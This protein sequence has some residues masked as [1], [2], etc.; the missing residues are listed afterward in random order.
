MGLHVSDL[1]RTDT[2]IPEGLA[3]ESFLTVAVGHR[4]P[5][6]TSV[7]IDGRPTD[8]GEDPQAVPNRVV[9]SA[10]HHRGDPFAA[11]VAGRRCVERAATAVGGQG[12]DL[13]EVDG[14]LGR[15]H[16]VDRCGDGGVAVP[17]PQPLA[18]LVNRHKR[19]GTGGVDR[20]VRSL[21]AE[22]VGQPPRSD[23]RRRAGPRIGVDVAR[24][25]EPAADLQ[26][27]VGADAD[28]HTRG[29]AVEATGGDPGILN[30][31]PDALQQQPLLRVHANGLSRRDAEERRIER[32][33][34]GEESPLPDVGPAGGI[35]VR[36]EIP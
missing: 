5:G 25:T 1:P 16:E 34:V 4:Q 30:R 14:R 19:R 7:V 33:D 6:R 35:G 36:V 32:F 10:Q 3:D 28:I 26:E 27:V 31:P 12:P 11:D 13:R 20:E 21:E 18:C 15:E 17:R 9:E 2:G 24:M 22:A 23:A 29:G 8:D